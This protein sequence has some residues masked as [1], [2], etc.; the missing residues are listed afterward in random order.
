MDQAIT[1]GSQHL[2]LTTE[3]EDEISISTMRSDLLEECTN[4]FKSSLRTAWKMGLVLRFVD[5]GIRIFHFMFCSCF[6]MEWLPFFCF[7]CAALGLGE[8]HCSGFQGKLECN[9][10]FGD[11][12]RE[13]SGRKGVFEKHGVGCSGGSEEERMEEYTAVQ[14]IPMVICLASLGTEHSITLSNHTSSN[15]KSRGL[16]CWSD[17]LSVENQTYNALASPSSPAPSP[18]IHSR[19]FPKVLSMGF[20][21]LFSGAHKSPSPKLIGKPFPKNEPTNTPLWPMIGNL[22]KIARAQQ[23]NVQNFNMKA[24]EYLWALGFIEERGVL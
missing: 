22:K 1:G 10:L 24:Q 18:A 5:M 4:A 11:W 13:N 19:V 2:H 12:T 3:E 23:K 14:H 7:A 6:Q 15:N 9:K 17:V 8:N 21:M 20:Q 16:G